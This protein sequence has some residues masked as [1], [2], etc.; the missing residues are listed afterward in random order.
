[1]SVGARR[2]N[3]LQFFGPVSDAIVISTAK[4]SIASQRCPRRR[5]SLIACWLLSKFTTARPIV[6]SF[7]PL[8][9]VENGKL[10]PIVGICTSR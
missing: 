4:M 8:L 5:F 1:M 6:G 9:N 7:S 3:L 10:P 2:K